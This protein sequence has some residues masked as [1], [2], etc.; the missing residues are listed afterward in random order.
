MLQNTPV[1]LLA[2]VCRR[3]VKEILNL[4]QGLDSGRS[5]PR[6]QRGPAF[7][8]GPEGGGGGAWKMEWFQFHEYLIGV[9]T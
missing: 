8:K 9:A 5:R 3:R 1:A 2:T 7:E 4:T 6:A